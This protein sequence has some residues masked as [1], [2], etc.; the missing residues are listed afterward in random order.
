MRPRP[1]RPP[2]APPAKAPR[3][4]HRAGPHK[5][6]TVAGQ[7]GPAAACAEPSREV[8]GVSGQD[9][10]PSRTVTGMGGQGQGLFKGSEGC[11]GQ[12]AFKGSVGCGWTGTVC[13]HGCPIPG[14]AAASGVS[15]PAPVLACVHARRLHASG[16]PR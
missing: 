13:R 16:C 6:A 9:R 7:A 15:A 10:V 1:K 11:G 14:A 12:G 2:N 5:A 4:R 8:W 3:A